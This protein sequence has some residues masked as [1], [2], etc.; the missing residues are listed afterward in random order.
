VSRR[1]S[2]G[3]GVNLLSKCIESVELCSNV[4][5]CQSLEV[6]CPMLHHLKNTSSPNLRHLGRAPYILC[7]K[8]QTQ[9][10]SNCFCVSYFSSSVGDALTS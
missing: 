6:L 1:S 7:P 2:V 5:M 8:T 3:V 9:V 10:P 4:E